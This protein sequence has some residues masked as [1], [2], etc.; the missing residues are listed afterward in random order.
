MNL[1]IDPMRSEKLRS[2]LRLHSLSIE[3]EVLEGKGAPVPEV[4]VESLSLSLQ[5]VLTRRVCEEETVRLGLKTTAEEQGAEAGR[6][7]ARPREPHCSEG[8]PHIT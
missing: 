4:Q 2:P 6:R 7:P 5:L 3:S 8:L 1:G